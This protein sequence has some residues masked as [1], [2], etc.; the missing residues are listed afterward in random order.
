LGKIVPEHG[1][2]AGQEPNEPEKAWQNKE[3][4]VEQGMISGAIGGPL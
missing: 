1:L 4:T 2:P 3:L